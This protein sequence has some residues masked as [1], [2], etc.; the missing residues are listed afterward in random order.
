[1]RMINWQWNG[2]LF[3][4]VNLYVLSFANIYKIIMKKK[5][6]IWLHIAMAIIIYVVYKL[7]VYNDLIVK[8]NSS[9]EH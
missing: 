5:S 8:K 9:R 2:H 1:M 6:Q 4:I 3:I 7:Y